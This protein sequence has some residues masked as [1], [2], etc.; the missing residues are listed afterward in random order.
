MQAVADL[1]ENKR[2]ARSRWDTD[3]AF[4]DAERACVA[5]TEVYAMDA[6]AISDEQAFSVKT[7]F[8]DAGL[9]HL[10]EAL[11]VFDGAIRLGQLWQLHTADAA[12]AEV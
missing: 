4:S 8:G 11:G 7:H 1:P 2:E 10:I 9:V 6:Q 3:P 12:A 5:F